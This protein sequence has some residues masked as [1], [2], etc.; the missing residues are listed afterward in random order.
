[1]KVFVAISFAMLGIICAITSEN[2]WI[3]FAGVTMIIISIIVSISM[4][5]PNPNKPYYEEH[6]L[7]DAK[8][9]ACSQK[10]FIYSDLYGKRFHRVNSSRQDHFI[11]CPT[12][13]WQSN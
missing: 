12:D 11:P 5:P 10:A 2:K 1:M 7:P 9:K 8:C 6:A 4:E 3:T 13:T